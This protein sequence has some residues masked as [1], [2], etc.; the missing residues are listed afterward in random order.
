M[1]ITETFTQILQEEMNGKTAKKSSLI[2]DWLGTTHVPQSVSIRV[3]NYL[4]TF[5]CKVMGDYNKLDMLI[6][7]GR[8]SIITAVSYTHLTLPTKA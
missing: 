7:K 5:F 2:Q 4:E 6:L 3:G 1:N 8:N